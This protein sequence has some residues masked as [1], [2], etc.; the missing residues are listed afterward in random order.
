MLFISY[1]NDLAEVSDTLHTILFADD[2][3]VTIEGKN[4]AELINILNTKLQKLNCWLEAN[5]LT[6]NVSK[7]NFMV[8][9]RGKRKIDVSNPCLNNIELKRVKYFNFLG[10]IDD[11]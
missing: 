9:H 11:C 4:E 2:T 7:S 1:I 5:K 6:I 8:F 10:V 3:I